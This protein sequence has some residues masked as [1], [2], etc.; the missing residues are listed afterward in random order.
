MRFLCFSEDLAKLLSDGLPYPVFYFCGLRSVDV[1]CDCFG[2]SHERG[3]G[4]PE[5][6]HQG[7]FPRLILPLSAVLSGLA[8]FGIAF[9]VMLA[10]LVEYGLHPGVHLI[11]LL[12]FLLLALVTALGVGLWLSA[13]NALYRDV[14]SAVRC[15]VLDAGFAGGVREQPSTC[16]MAR[17][18]R[19]KPG[20]RCH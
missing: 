19:A 15:A 8:D 18:V 10:L 9:L 14:R 2:E 12:F 4:K 7:V 11:W 16:E 1:F 17:A 3:C 20:G 6:D 13:L 5:S